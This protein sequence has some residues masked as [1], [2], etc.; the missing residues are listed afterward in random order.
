MLEKFAENVGA[1]FRVNRMTSKLITTGLLQYEKPDR[2]GTVLTEQ[3]LDAVR[4]SLET[5]PIHLSNDHITGWV[6]RKRLHEETQNHDNC[7]RTRE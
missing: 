1:C 6:F 2:K 3:K 4:D 7:D 5:S